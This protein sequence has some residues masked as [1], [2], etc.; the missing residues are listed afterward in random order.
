[1]GEPGRVAGAEGWCDGC[2]DREACAQGGCHLDG[3]PVKPDASAWV[4]PYVAAPLDPEPARTVH[5]PVRRVVAITRY[6]ALALGAVVVVALVATGDQPRAVPL[7]PIPA[8]AAT[9][10]TTTTVTVPPI[11]APEETV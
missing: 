4:P 11:T 8:P 5:L 7:T 9:T 2:P 3:G 6:V 10:W 1:M